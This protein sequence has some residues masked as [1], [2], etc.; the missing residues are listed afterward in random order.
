MTTSRARSVGLLAGVLADRLLGDPRRFHP[1]AG[2]G[3]LAAGLE[4]IDYRDART[5][6]VLHV[7][8]L[9]GGTALLGRTLERSA[10]RPVTRA[11]VTAAAT[12]AVL[13]GRSLQR[14]ALTI[15]GRLRSG[16]LE[17]ARLQITHLVG[18][19]PSRLDAAQITRATIESVAENTA[20]A[21]V[22]PLFWGAMAGMP[23]LLAYRAANTLDAMIGH[24]RPRYENY[25]W[26]AARLDDV[27]NFVP[28]RLCVVVV[29]LCAP[30]VGGRPMDALRAARRDGPGHPSPNA[31]PVE[32]AF[33]GAL[34]ITLGGVNVYAGRVEDRGTLGDGPPP[35]VPDI[36]RVARLSAAVTLVTSIS[37]AMLGS[38]IGSRRSRR[39][40]PRPWR[41]R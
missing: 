11:V 14:E 34:G 9:V 24:H 28:A 4:Q 3:R 16:E 10:A 2:F 38:A 40:R 27:L 5:A 41:R 30:V 36:A 21:V 18:R 35:E 13:G 26:A 23:G 22:S 8:L 32:A 1:V 17:A 15:S 20:D 31:G 37:A 39:R 6:G 33:A 19:D 12:F 7:G 29:A 25:G